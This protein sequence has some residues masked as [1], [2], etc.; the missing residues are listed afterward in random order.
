MTPTEIREARIKL[1][2]TPPQMAVMLGY[3]ERGASERISEI[4]NG[5]RKPDRS[6]VL[7]LEA[8]LDGYR[9]AAWP[10]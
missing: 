2:L 9:P 7:L 5:V 3:G 4:E 1:G 8:Y 6:K 10:A